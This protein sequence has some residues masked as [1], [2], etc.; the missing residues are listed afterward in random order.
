MYDPAAA[1]QRTPKENKAWYVD[2]SFVPETRT[3]RD[4]KARR[5]ISELIRSDRFELPPMPAVAQEVFAAANRPNATVQELARIAHRDPFIAGRVLKVAN[6]AAYGFLNPAG[7]LK[8]AIVRIGMQEFRNIILVLGMKGDVF[9]SKEF[10]E[11]GEAA[12]SHSLA[13]AIACSIIAKATRRVEGHRA[14]LAGLMHDIGVSVVVKA[15]IVHVQNKPE[16]KAY[17]REFLPLIA[18]DLHTEIGA[19]VGRRWRLDDGL[20]DAIAYHHA[21]SEAEEEPT[22]AIH[23]AL[24]DSAAHHIGARCVTTPRIPYGPKPFRAIGLDWGMDET[25]ENQLKEKVE[26]YQLAVS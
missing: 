11:F 8:D 5:E 9:R 26:E 20:V 10:Q 16:D 17:M 6:S 15:A 1:K 23:V 19:L 13:T 7:T 18:A 12:W 3:E 14:F 21:P 24:A 25:F 4:E 22:L 2:P